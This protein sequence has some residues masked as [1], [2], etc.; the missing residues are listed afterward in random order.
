M[1]V[2]VCSVTGP[3]LIRDLPFA[4]AI[5][6]MSCGG[7]ELRKCSKAEKSLVACINI[8]KSHDASK[9]LCDFTVMSAGVSHLVLQ[10]LVYTAVV[11]DVSQQ[12]LSSFN[13]D[14]I[15]IHT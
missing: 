9:V 7:G 4:S 2:C 13:A 5:K 1:A 8:H 10:E 6:M 15:C 12:H 11:S 3:V 14:F